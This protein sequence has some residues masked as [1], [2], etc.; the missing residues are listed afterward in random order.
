MVP[1]EMRNKPKFSNYNFRI[2]LS[3]DLFNAD[4]PE[5]TDVKT[6]YL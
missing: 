4:Y 2:V 5:Y 1:S 6:L 3:V